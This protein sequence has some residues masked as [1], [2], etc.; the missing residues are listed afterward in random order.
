MV[1]TYLTHIFVTLDAAL[2]SARNA[3]VIESGSNNATAL[4]KGRKDLLRD[5]N[6]SAARFPLLRKSLTKPLN[7]MT[8]TLV[9]ARASELRNS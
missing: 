8:F 9:Y 6:G 4:E 1:I 2:R 5:R 7:L 3:I